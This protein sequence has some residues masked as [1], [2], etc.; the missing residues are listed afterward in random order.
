MDSFL[1]IFPTA[2]FAL[3]FYLYFPFSQIRFGASPYRANTTSA[4]DDTQIQQFLDPLHE[5]LPFYK[6]VNLTCCSD[7]RP[8]MAVELSIA[9]IS[10][11]I[12]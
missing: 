4:K 11:F 7:I 9:L 1:D 5:E 6:S 12:T 8:T 2:D 3:C 10:P